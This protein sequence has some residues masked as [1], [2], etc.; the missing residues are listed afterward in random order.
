MFDN[1]S[2]PKT[3]NQSYNS[4]K[5]IR[6]VVTRIVFKNEENGYTVLKMNSESSS[7]ITVVGKFVSVHIGSHLIVRGNESSHSKYGSQFNAISS[8]ETEPSS[9]KDIEKYLASGLVK[10]IGPK[11]A[12][13]IVEFFGEKTIE[14]IHKQPDA[15]AKISGVGLHK[16]RLLQE[17]FT[18]Q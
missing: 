13:R 4:E 15:L 17:A 12:E 14:M 16:A 3:T 1:N 9:A 11:T 5:V 10:G 18:E 2:D 7:E 8:T 6:G